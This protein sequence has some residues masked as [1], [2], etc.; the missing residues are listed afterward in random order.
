MCIIGELVCAWIVC[1]KMAE[2]W[3]EPQRQCDCKDATSAAN[4]HLQLSK[5]VSAFIRG[6]LMPCIDPQTFHV[7]PLWHQWIATWLP[8]ENQGSM[9]V[10]N[11]YKL[12]VSRTV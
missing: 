1:D 4:T 9:S 11:V 2:H 10:K 3:R 12:S 6:R 7:L 5:Y 8:W